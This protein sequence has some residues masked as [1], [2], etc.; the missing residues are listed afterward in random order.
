MNLHPGQSLQISPYIKDVVEVGLNWEGRGVNLD[1][2]IVLI[3]DLG[4]I[5]DAVY[6][7]KTASD[8]KSVVH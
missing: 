8:C 5:T 3:N 6:Y 1:A 2:S 4:N 7:N